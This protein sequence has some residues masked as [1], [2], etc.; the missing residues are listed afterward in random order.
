MYTVIIMVEKIQR[1]I[2]QR[3]DDRR[4]QMQHDAG[5]LSR[6]ISASN[7]VSEDILEKIRTIF[8]TKEEDELLWVSGKVIFR[9][10]MLVNEIEQRLHSLFEKVYIE[11][12]GKLEL[13]YAYREE[14]GKEQNK[15]DLIHSVTSKLEEVKQKN[16]M[17][18]NHSSF[19]F[20]FQEVCSNLHIDKKSEKMND[21]NCFAKDMD[22]LVLANR[23]NKL[24]QGES[25]DG[26]IAIVKADL[27][28]MGSIFSAIS[29]YEDYIKL[30]SLLKRKIARTHLEEMITNGIRKDSK[31]IEEKRDP[32]HLKGR[33]LPFY[34]EGDDIFYAV[35]IDALLDSIGLLSALVRELNDDIYKL[36]LKSVKQKIGISIGVI[37]TNNHQ[38]IRY[39]REAV[40]S[41]LSR[42]KHRMKKEKGS[43]AILGISLTG[44]CFFEYDGMMGLREEDGFKRFVQEIEELKWMKK[45]EV[46]TRT[47]IYNLVEVLEK[48]EDENRCSDP[49]QKD[50]RSLK[51]R[52]DKRKI[53]LLLY[54]LMLEFKETEQSAYEL[55]FKYYLLSQVIEEHKGKGK[56][57]G[58]D[59]DKIENAL[60]PKLKLILLLTDERFVS[61]ERNENLQFRYILSDKK[62]DQ[63]SSV[64]FTKPLNYIYASSQRSIVSLFISREKQEISVEDSYTKKS[65]T[66]N[67]YKKAKFY[68]SI[69]FRA[70]KLIEEGRGERA[71]KLICN[72]F[73]ISKENLGDGSP[74]KSVVDH[75]KYFDMKEFEKQFD[76]MITCRSTEWLDDLILFYKYDEQ[77]IKREDY[78]RYTTS[79]LKNLKERK[80]RK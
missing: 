42:V 59:V 66:I 28:N 80:G 9:T 10:D 47:S 49:K 64:M 71:K 15:M 72:A 57:R 27:N 68:P 65:K 19:L 58:F 29:D 4:S 51:E 3:I 21:N 16:H 40:E 1:Y 22:E 20:E 8:K 56:E 74:N 25:T 32:S 67:V 46:F 35:D 55:L 26:K 78:K 34:I 50:D 33:I 31:E 41:E 75:E 30:S 45:K 54:F 60:I 7:S 24:N 61:L 43:R 11:Y 2:Y 5:T 62:L 73:T 37:F 70:K 17:I 36:E 13:K 77:R 79:C 23:R 44:N 63:I 6:I 18:Q 14:D 76:E 52:N 12:G 53:Q 38:P 48:K 69:F 39:Y